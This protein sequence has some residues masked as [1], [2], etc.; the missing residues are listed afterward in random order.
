[1]AGSLRRAALIF[2]EEDGVSV[3][4]FD[5]GSGSAPG[6]LA[7][8]RIPGHHPVPGC[9]PGLRIDDQGSTHIS[10]L[11][12]TAPDSTELVVAD[13]TLDAAKQWVSPPK[14]EKARKLPAQ[15]VTG[16]IT[17][18]SRTDRPMRRDW[19]VLLPDGSVVHS[20]SQDRPM[21][22]Q[23]KPVTP[24]QMVARSQATYLL[25][26]RLEGPYLEMLR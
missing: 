8:L 11:L 14:L 3:Q 2:K 9:D 10:L 22:P 26:L 17:F 16:G 5:V 18:Q 7:T 4:V 13:A 25:T 6:S 19:A 24:L 1:L 12:S 20:L 15:P 23:G 21:R